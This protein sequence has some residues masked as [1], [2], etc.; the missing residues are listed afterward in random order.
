MNKVKNISRVGAALLI[1]ATAVAVHAEDGDITQARTQDRTRTE[2][3]LQVP[4]SDFGQSRNRE[5]HTVMNQNQNQNQ[6]QYQYK[7]MNQTK[8]GNSGAL[9]AER[10]SETNRHVQGS[11]NTGS[12]SRQNMAGSNAGRGHR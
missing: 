7:Y 11:V 12:M 4:D 9:A 1:G 2:L 8:K 10:M 5:E 6:Y 3:N